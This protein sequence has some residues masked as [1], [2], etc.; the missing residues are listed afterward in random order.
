MTHQDEIRIG[1]TERDAVMVALHDHF[2]AGRLDR[3]EL[4]ERLGTA[5]AAKTHGDLRGLVRDLPGPS[6]LA[7]P[8]RNPAPSYGPVPWGPHPGHRQLSH[9]HWHPHRGH[10]HGGFP[11]GPL[12]LG[13]FLVLA[14]TV[15]PG[16]GFLVI[17]QIAL[18][19]WVVRAALMA[20][21]LRRSRR[22][23]P[24]LSSRA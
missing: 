20:F 15:G 3:D 21:G 14:F 7:E 1:D 8:E 10:R 19:L 2:A 12:L 9:Q 11:K 23:E 17:L 24:R 13:V 22:G 16:M 18:V 5:L 6:G 4:D